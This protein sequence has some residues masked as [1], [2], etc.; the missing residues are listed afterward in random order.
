MHG[1]MDQVSATQLQGIAVQAAVLHLAEP[2]GSTPAKATTA[3]AAGTA[4][5]A[6][7]VSSGRAGRDVVDVSDEGRRLY[8]ASFAPRPSD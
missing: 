8:E 3:S 2:A 7:A 5:V 1:A 4:G 6:A